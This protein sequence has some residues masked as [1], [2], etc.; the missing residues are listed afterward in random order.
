VT[1]CAHTL[2]DS[3]VRLCRRLPDPAPPLGALSRYLAWLAHTALLMS[4]GGVASNRSARQLVALST[5]ARSRILRCGD[6]DPKSAGGPDKLGTLRT[7]AAGGP[8][9]CGEAHAGQ[10]SP[11]WAGPGGGNSGLRW[12]KTPG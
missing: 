3:V 10:P 4:V 8:E 7:N 5:D 2:V 9:G 12:L 6:P 11:G 1:G